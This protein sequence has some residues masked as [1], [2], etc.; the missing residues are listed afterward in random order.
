[1][2]V[3][4]YK[5]Y[6]FFSFGIP[7]LNDHILLVC[8]SVGQMIQKS[9]FVHS[10]ADNSKCK[11]HWALKMFEQWRFMRNCLVKEGSFT[12]V[13]IEKHFNAMTVDDLNY[14]VP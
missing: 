10:Y 6:V 2:T 5:R 7:R 1:M 3:N 8:D 12:G 11:H 9:F 4:S 13:P 14:A